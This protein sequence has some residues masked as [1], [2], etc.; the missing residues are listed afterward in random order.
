MVRTRH[1]DTP[2]ISLPARRLWAVSLAGA[3]AALAGCS[4]DP[5]SASMGDPA[6]FTA[7]HVR[8][9][10]ASLESA[11]GRRASPLADLDR[12]FRS[13]PEAYKTGKLRMDAMLDSTQRHR[14]IA[15]AVASSLAL[16]LALAG[17]AGEA[18][19]SGGS[20]KGGE[21]NPKAAAGE[22]TNPQ[23]KSG[24]DGGDKKTG[25][26]PRK[27]D[28]SANKKKDGASGDGSGKVPKKEPGKEDPEKPGDG[29]NGGKGGGSSLADEV[30]RLADE[31]AKSAESTVPADSPFDALDR[32]ADFFTAFL[33]KEL[34]L[35]GGDSR[36]L[37][38]KQ[39]YSVWA[40]A[41]QVGAKRAKL[42]E[43]EA[44]KPDSKPE[45]KPDPKPEPR[46]ADIAMFELMRGLLLGPS[47]NAPTVPP[48]PPPP[49][50][51]EQKPAKLGQ[52]APQEQH[53]AGQVPA[54]PVLRAQPIG[55]IMSIDKERDST[56][57]GSKSDNK[58][59]DERKDGK[60]RR[61]V[62]QVEPQAYENVVKARL[63][64]ELELDQR[65]RT[66]R[67]SWVSKA[68]ALRKEINTSLKAAP[69]KKKPEKPKPSTPT[70]REEYEKA[71][72]E[73]DTVVA[74][75]RSAIEQSPGPQA[76]RLILLVLQAHVHP[77]TEKNYM[78]GLRA[79]VVSCR[80][81]VA[82]SAGTAYATGTE[83]ASPSSL[84]NVVRVVRLHP[85]RNYDVEDQMFAQSLSE[86]LSLT[87]SGQFATDVQGKLAGALAEQAAEKRR[88]LSRVPKLC[89]WSDAASGEFGWNFY[90][91][92][93]AVR[94]RSPTERLSGLVY[95]PNFTLYA[96][97]AYLE[98]GARDC[99]AYLVVPT[100][101][102]S[103]T[104]EIEQVVA[105]LDGSDHERRGTL[106]GRDASRSTIVIDLPEY[107]P[108]EHAAMLGN[109]VHGDVVSPNL[110]PP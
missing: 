10:Q 95:A 99:A 28:T 67:A 29:T 87:V 44:R 63:A 42:A 93:L 7:L 33:L 6:V 9:A 48:A 69:T 77:G 104:L 38:A 27:D 60:N 89:S 101:L 49:A 106:G 13:T 62:V 15:Q 71:V 80:D 58:N 75:A 36:A 43:S 73:Y 96:V 98:G 92:N 82:Q 74:S 59:E 61:P 81:G 5:P 64:A 68:D 21:Q 24:Q 34:R 78:V 26:Q 85:T 16:E 1:D 40:A 109:M 97:D 37:P 84:P 53:A 100:T 91:S 41:E 35:F 50:A 79:R 83:G 76:Q 47:N 31:L 108:Y 22:K 54:P 19:K 23:S 11:T 102:K 45:P 32:S 86:Q 90:P 20:G 51:P 56:Q 88:F 57:G 94:E 103:F 105:P 107:T 2:R 52:T 66:E 46:A 30:R 110:A 70:P 14:A 18:D 8:A 65:E 39:M 17:K 55:E 72:K 12:Y 25:E 4:Y 3:V